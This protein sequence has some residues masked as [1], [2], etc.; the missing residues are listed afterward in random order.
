MTEITLLDPIDDE[1]VPRPAFLVAPGYAMGIVGG[2]LWVDRVVPVPGDPTTFK[3]DGGLSLTWRIG[4]GNE[5]VAEVY[6]RL[7][8][9]TGFDFVTQIMLHP[10][11]AYDLEMYPDGKAL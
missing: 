10:D 6:A 2:A 1:L 8:S 11:N 7:I 3:G 9:M 4:R 5:L